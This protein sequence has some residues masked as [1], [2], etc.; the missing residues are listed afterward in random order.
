MKSPPR[1]RLS[2]TAGRAHLQIPLLIEEGRDATIVEDGV[3][4]DCY[5]LRR[6]MI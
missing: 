5:S 4:Y 2:I 3:V 6:R 1:R